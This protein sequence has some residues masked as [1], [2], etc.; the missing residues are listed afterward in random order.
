M[1][2]SDKRLKT[3]CLY[4][5]NCFECDLRKLKGAADDA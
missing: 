4:M 1:A 2:L 5:N 3:I